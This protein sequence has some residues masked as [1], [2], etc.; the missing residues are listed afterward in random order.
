[1]KFLFWEGEIAHFRRARFYEVLADKIYW[2]WYR[3]LNPR[4]LILYIGKDDIIINKKVLYKKGE[5]HELY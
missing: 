4:N 1:M 2:W 5:K 3:E